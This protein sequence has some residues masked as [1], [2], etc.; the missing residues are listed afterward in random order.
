MKNVAIVGRANVG[1]STL[2]NRIAKK[3]KAITQ[4]MPGVTRDRIGTEV[5]IKGISFFLYDTGGLQLDLNEIIQ[6]EVRKQV[7]LALEQADLILFVVDASAGITWEDELVAKIVRKKDKNVVL[8]ANKTDKIGKEQEKI[9]EFYS[10]GF[11]DIVSISAEHNQNIDKILEKI[12]EILGKSSFKTS[13]DKINSLKISI[14]GKPNVGKS[15]LLNSIIGEERAIVSDIAG[16]TRDVIDVTFNHNGVPF[17][18]LDTAGIRK[19]AKVSED[20]EYFSVIRAIQSIR[21][22]DIV[23][24]VVDYNEFSITEQDKKIISLAFEATK[25]IIVC[26]NKFD[27]KGKKE[28]KDEIVQKVKSSLYFCQTNVVFTSA[29]NKLGINKLLDKCI[30]LKERNNKKIAT[31]VL[32]SLLQEMVTVKAP[33]N[34]KEKK[35]RI[36]YGVQVKTSPPTFVIFCN[37]PDLIHFSYLRYLE[38][39]FRDAFDLEG[40]NIKIILRDSRKQE[41]KIF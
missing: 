1:K 11:K 38:N 9:F 32:N 27:E 16:T 7:E 36:T 18:I 21:N 5:N 35:V 3:R 39:N 28:E 37:H 14:V 22:S 8:L 40:I 24:V 2:F 41:G 15:S 10:L 12:I 20:V 4:E 31:G 33:S 34:K 25:P 19:K 17:T 13:E 30:E 29:I 26:V 23:V 6:N